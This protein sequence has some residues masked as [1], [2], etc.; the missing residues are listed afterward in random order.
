[1]SDIYIY[2]YVFDTLLI[3]RGVKMDFGVKLTAGHTESDGSD[4]GVLRSVSDILIGYSTVLGFTSNRNKYLGTWY[5]EAICEIFMEH[6]CDTDVEDMLKM[7][8][9]S[10]F[11]IIMITWFP[12]FVSFLF[13]KEEVGLLPFSGEVCRPGSNRKSCFQSLHRIYQLTACM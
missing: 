9:L 12:D 1:M 4:T 2:I 5:I 8:R 13:L 7:V 11:I 10:A 6:A 3:F